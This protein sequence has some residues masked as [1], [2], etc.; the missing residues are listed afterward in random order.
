MTDERELKYQTSY[1]GII[2]FVKLSRISNYLQFHLCQCWS[3]QTKLEWDTKKENKMGMFL[4][5]LMQGKPESRGTFALAEFGSLRTRFRLILTCL[6]Y[7]WSHV[8]KNCKGNW[9]SVWVEHFHKKKLLRLVIYSE[10]NRVCFRV[11]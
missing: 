6:L 2:L 8:S 1:D 7:H 5:S 3:I 4:N 9:G 11:T 10:I